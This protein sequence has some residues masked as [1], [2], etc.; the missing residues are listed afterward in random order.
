MQ[1]YMTK[2]RFGR[3]CEVRNNPVV[4][5]LLYIAMEV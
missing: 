4:D 1:D 5:L 2:G 3:A